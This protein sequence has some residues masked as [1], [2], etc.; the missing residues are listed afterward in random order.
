LPG[1]NLVGLKDDWGHN[2][3]WIDYIKANKPQEL[4]DL[5]I[6]IKKYFG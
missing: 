6:N 2:K 3:N 5:V 4:I 1:K